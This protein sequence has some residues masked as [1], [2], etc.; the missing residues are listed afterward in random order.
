MTITQRAKTTKSE[1]FLPFT[2]SSCSSVNSGNNAY[3]PA[4]DICMNKRDDDDDDAA[5]DDD[6]D[7]DAGD[8]GDAVEEWDCEDRL[9]SA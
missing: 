1:A 7:V 5:G 6:I 4:I 9:T 2:G 3:V 8:I